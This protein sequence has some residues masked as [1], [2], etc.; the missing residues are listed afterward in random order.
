MSYTFLYP[1]LGNCCVVV[2]GAGGLGQW[3]VRFA[4]ALY[5]PETQIICAD[6]KVLYLV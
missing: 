3:G 5:P 1:L 4:R 2:F 6:I